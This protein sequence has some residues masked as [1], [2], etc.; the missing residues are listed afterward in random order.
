[1]SAVPASIASLSQE[2]LQ[3]ALVDSLKKLK[4]SDIG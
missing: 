3:K 4:V 1:M 2:Q